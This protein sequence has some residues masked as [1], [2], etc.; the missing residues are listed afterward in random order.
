LKCSG[1]LLGK[2]F[3][4]ENQPR[5]EHFR[6]FLKSSKKTI[7]RLEEAILNSQFAEHHMTRVTPAKDLDRRPVTALRKFNP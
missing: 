6:E 1:F 2:F 3:G 5:T 7:H 4:K